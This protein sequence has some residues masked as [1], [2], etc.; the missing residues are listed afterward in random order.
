MAFGTKGSA[1]CG[2][3]AARLVSYDVNSKTYQ[4]G[5]GL[6]EL[7]KSA[8]RLNDFADIARPRLQALASRFNMTATATSKTDDQHLALVAFANGSPNG[9]RLE[10]KP[11]DIRD[12]LLELRV[13]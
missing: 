11:D 3:A 7:A 5:T 10:V 9:L 13:V 6:V 2:T 4:L 12:L 1:R 8:T